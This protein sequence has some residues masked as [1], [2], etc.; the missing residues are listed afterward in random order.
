LA[1]LDAHACTAGRCLVIPK[2]EG[3]CNILDIW[4]LQ[5]ATTLFQEFFVAK[6]LWD[7]FKCDGINIIHNNGAAA[8]Q[9]VIHAHIHKNPRY[10]KDNLIYF[11]PTRREAI[12]KT[13]A[14]SVLHKFK[15]NIENYPY[16]TYLEISTCDVI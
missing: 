2:A 5:V 15:K 13:D 11:A 12:Q 16:K 1:I 14:A 10:A 7:V 3:Y 8:G 9:D 6:S 4:L